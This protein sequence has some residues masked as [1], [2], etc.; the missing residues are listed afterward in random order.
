MN[1]REYQDSIKKCR[2]C[3]D[4]D[5]CSKYLTFEKP[6]SYFGESE[7]NIVI[8]GHS[9]KVRSV[10]RAKTVL[11]MDETKGQLYKYVTE[12]IIKQLGLNIDNCYCTN[13]LKCETSIAPEDIK[14]KEAKYRFFNDVLR[15][16]KVLFENEISIINPKIIIGLS[17]PVLK[18]ISKNYCGI[19]NKDSSMA[20]AFGKLFKIKIAGKEYGYIPVVHYTTRKNVKEHYFD[21]EDNQISR[22]KELSKEIV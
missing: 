16:C 2:K 8:L 5:I 18:F 17:E 1:I 20:D 4:D 9:P 11:K 10:K 14:P 13:L 19:E 15:N 12:K 22:L 3:S 6:D 7:L 21:K